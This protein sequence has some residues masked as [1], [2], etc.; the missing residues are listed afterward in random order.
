[1]LGIRADVPVN[2]SAR[3]APLRAPSRHVARERI[4]DH[5]DVCIDW[6]ASARPGV[7]ATHAAR[8]RAICEWFQST[9]LKSSRFE[10]AE[11]RGTLLSPPTAHGAPSA[12]RLSGCPSPA[13]LSEAALSDRVK[14]HRGTHVNGCDS[15]SF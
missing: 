4:F 1:M 3:A 10:Q 9:A 2:R 11:A 7:I 13:V 14:T 8:R 15:L 12:C 5:R 6:F